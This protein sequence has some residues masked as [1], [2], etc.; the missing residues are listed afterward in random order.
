MADVVIT[1]ITPRLFRA[2][3]TPTPVPYANP[4][5]SW[6]GDAPLEGSF[7]FRE[8]LVVEVELSTGEI[9]YG[10]TG[11]AAVLGASVVEKYLAPLVVGRRAADIEQIWQLMYRSTV[12]F[13]R[14]GV[15][16]AAISAVDIGIWDAWARHLNVPVYDILGGRRN[17][18]IRV[19]A[20]RLYAQ[21]S[22]EDLA[23]EAVR[24]RDQGYTAVKQR[25]VW[26]P[27][28]GR[29]GM[30]R[31]VELMRTV[32]EA[33][34]PDVEIMGDV[35]MGWDLP[36]AKQMLRMLEP[37]DV[38]WIEEPLVP[39]DVEGYAALRG[40]TSIPIAGGEHEFTL[41]GCADLLNRRAVDVLQCDTNRVGGLTQ[42][43]K[44]AALAESRGVPL[45]PHGG[46]QHNYH[47]V[48]SQPAC[49]MAEHFPL[50]SIEVG[51]ELPA[52]VFSGE[53]A[54]TDGYITL[55]EVP[56]LDL[57]VDPRYPVEEVVL[58]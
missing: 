32:R 55:A 43:R 33:V 30:L 21:G 7:S 36:Y 53:P 6:L 16:M 45:V 47:L 18:T 42:A 19:Y 46:Q 12:A 28:D 15:G 26:G 44:I 8:W 20:S 25:F 31:N 13:G 58:H 22:L 35:Y 11:L 40:L 4:L 17:D 48:T 14:K 54:A 49:P 38:S 37:F 1:R 39:D 24:Y 9:G 34:G 5:R 3:D 2:V 41:A 51:N 10:N 27:A 50:D 29:Q 23:A 52:W 57:K 56:G